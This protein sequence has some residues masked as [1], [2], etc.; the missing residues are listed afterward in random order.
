MNKYV[1]GFGER[2]GWIKLCGGV[3]KLRVFIVLGLDGVLGRDVSRGFCRVR[4]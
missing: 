2:S 3:S 1:W 4:G